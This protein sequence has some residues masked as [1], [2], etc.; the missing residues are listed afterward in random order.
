M[1]NNRTAQLIFQT[2]YCALGI[3]GMVASTGFFD[4]RYAQG[5]YMHFTNLSNYLC[6]GIMLLCLIRTARKKED[7][8]VEVPGP[9]YFTGMQG[10]LLTFLVFNIL[11]APDREAYLNFRVVSVLLHVVLPVMY[12]A[13]W[14]L[15]C[16]RRQV[17]WWYPP[18][19]LL[20]PLGYMIFVFVRGALWNF[21]PE[22]PHLFPYFFLNFQ[23]QGVG[24]VAMWMVALLV[25][26]QVTGFALMGLDRIGKKTGAKL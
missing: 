2:V 14:F 16:P 17:K 20:F 22:A 12:I 8:P 13:H 21:S 9:L 7:S 5:F 4:Y 1:K 11:L 3:L 26:L 19:S 25:L 6:I 24:G 10:I 23:T 18:V 15:F